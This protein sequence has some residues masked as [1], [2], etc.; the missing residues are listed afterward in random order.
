MRGRPV[1]SSALERDLRQLVGDRVAVSDFE[2][3]F[4]ARDIVRIPG[5]V[6][7]LVSATPDAVV[8]P[9]TADE[10]AAVVKYCRQQG[11]PVVPR[12]AG[13]S[14][15]FAS[16]PRKGGVVLDLL[17]LKR[18]TGV[19]PDRETITAD[20]GA[21]WWQVETE[22]QRHGMALRSYPS[23]ARSATLAGWMMTSGLGIGSL[24]YGPVFD[25]VLSAGIVLPDCTRQEY[26]AGNGLELF[27]ESEGMLGV[28]TDIT[29]RVRRAP[30]G[31]MS[32]LVRFGDF[33]DLCRALES[34]AA[35]EEHP[36]NVE[37][38]DGGYLALLRAAGYETTDFGEGGG[39]LLVTYD[40]EAAEI[41]DGK[42]RIADLCQRHHGVLVEG[43]DAEW[44]QRFNMLRVR[45]AAPSIVP[46]SV[47]VPLDRV[48]EFQARY[49]GGR[50]RPAGMSCRHD[51]LPGV[52]DTV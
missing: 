21:T 13:S 40:G 27:F 20:A 37:F 31:I 24:R 34:L 36:Y 52:R 15:L 33:A 43:G 12:G 32:F 39:T 10:V 7:S 25:H 38:Q 22:L 1:E 35:T 48:A 5:A 14:G 30:Q 19:D 26:T 2:R 49:R 4:Y 23:S 3:W 45:R 6:R 8:R 11:L 42:G 50:K 46:S 9:E 41:A 47:Y 28:V 44:G 16:V 18:V 29:L 17:G 51:R